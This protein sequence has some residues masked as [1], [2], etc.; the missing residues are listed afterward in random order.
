MKQIIEKTIKKT[1]KQVLKWKTFLENSHSSYRTNHPNRIQLVS[2]NWVLKDPNPPEIISLWCCSISDT[3]QANPKHQKNK[4]TPHLQL[5]P[6][7]PC[8]VCHSLLPPSTIVPGAVHH[9]HHDSIKL[10]DKTHHSFN[11]NNNRKNRKYRK[12]ANRPG[13]P[14][15]Q[16]LNFAFRATVRTR[17]D[18]ALDFFFTSPNHPRKRKLDRT[19]EDTH[20]HTLRNDPSLKFPSPSRKLPESIASRQK[21]KASPS[22]GLM[23]TRRCRCCLLLTFFLHSLLRY[24]ASVLKPSKGAGWYRQ[25]L[26]YWLLNFWIIHGVSGRTADRSFNDDDDQPQRQ[27]P[28]GIGWIDFSCNLF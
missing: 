11:Y 4:Q 7:S 5:Y 6:N 28:N 9:H 2:F 13:L 12:H 24:P 1:T 26:H 19:N 22:G 21:A 27:P 23:A 18:P 15:S 14:A 16:Q 3:K 8:S 10:W 17:C 25:T 20:T